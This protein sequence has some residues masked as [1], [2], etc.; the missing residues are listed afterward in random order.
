MMLI[1]LDIFFSKG[2]V[3]RILVT[4]NLSFNS[5]SYIVHAVDIGFVLF[6]VLN[7]ILEYLASYLLKFTYVPQ[8][9]IK[10]ANSSRGPIIKKEGSTNF[11]VSKTARRH[12]NKVK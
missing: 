8:V 4:L 10:R 5:Y 9:T 3:L 1:S 11:P 7:T 2:S 12:K 6:V